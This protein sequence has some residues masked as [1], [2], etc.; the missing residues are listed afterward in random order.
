MGGHRVYIGHLSRDAEKRDLEDLFKSYGRILD[1]TVKN[2]FGFVEFDDK[3]DAEDAVHDFHGTKFMGQRLI[4]ELAMS[5]RREPRNEQG[6]T[7]RIVVKNIPSK[8]T[9]QDLKDFMR[10]A[11]RVTFADILKDRD[12][13]GVV[14]FAKREDMKYA[15]RNLDNEKL[16]GQRVTLD[17]AGR[18]RK[19][20]DRSRSPRRSSRRRSRSASRSRSRSRSARSLTPRSRSRSPRS[21]SRSRSRSPRRDGDDAVMDDQPVNI[22]EEEVEI[23]AERRSASVQSRNSQD[24]RD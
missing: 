23:K 5:R 13:E 2:G 7:N 8:T 24:S 16:N 14:E 4:V 17:E 9:W 12:G 1:I 15:L 18:R 21:R 10:K 20:R 19:S 22:K 11:G 6:D 3:V